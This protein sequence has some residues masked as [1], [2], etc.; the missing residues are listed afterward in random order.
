MTAQ[1]FIGGA[2]GTFTLTGTD[3]KTGSFAGAKAIGATVIAACSINGASVTPATY[4]GSASLADGQLITVPYA[5]TDNRI[6]SITLTSGSL[7]LIKG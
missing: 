6:T 7:L 2:Y 5:N 4:F 3:A 1:E